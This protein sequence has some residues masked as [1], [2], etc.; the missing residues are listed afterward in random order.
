MP[1]KET[2]E[3]TRVSIDTFTSN[4]QDEKP[5]VERLAKRYNVPI[6]EVIHLI[7]ATEADTAANITKWIM[8]RLPGDKRCKGRRRYGYDYSGR[9][10][11][12]EQRV[13]A[14]VAMLWAANYPGSEIAKI[15]NSE[16][17]L[18]MTGLPWTARHVWHLLEKVGY[19]RD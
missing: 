16:G 18:T 10:I 17:Q 12:D 6:C 13:I 3:Q 15:L 14:R 11:I 7:G 5:P 8:D 9:P 1:V 19:D 4:R 2:N